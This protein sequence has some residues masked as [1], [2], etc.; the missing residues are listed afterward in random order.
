MPR[1]LKTPPATVF[2]PNC[3]FKAPQCDQGHQLF[4][5]I[6]RVGSQVCNSCW[7]RIQSTYTHRCRICDFDLCRRCYSS[8][9]AEDP[10]E[11]SLRPLLEESYSRS[12][13]RE[14][15]AGEHVAEPTLSAEDVQAGDLT[16]PL[17]STESSGDARP[18]ATDSNLAPFLQPHW[19]LAYP[20]WPLSEYRN[21]QMRVLYGDRPPVKLP[22]WFRGGSTRP[23]SGL[24]PAARALRD[25]TSE[26]PAATGTADPAQAANAAKPMPPGDGSV[27]ASSAAAAVAIGLHDPRGGV[28]QAASAVAALGMPQAE[29]WWRTQIAEKVAVAI[30]SPELPKSRRPSPRSASWRAK[31]RKDGITAAQRGESRFD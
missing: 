17:H 6:C 31:I 18:Q 21:E 22:A 30:G 24:R 25:A 19:R 16:D 28:A 15:G 2:R 11:A 8:P 14:R 9:G 1:G 23:T 7:R 3:A 29:R 12:S 10:L 26:M 27:A 13:S 20:D 4:I 5:C